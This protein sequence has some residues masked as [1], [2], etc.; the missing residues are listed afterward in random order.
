MCSFVIHVAWMKHF[1]RC[2]KTQN[3]CANG[4]VS[5][6]AMMVSSSGNLIQKRQGLYQQRQRR[7][8][9]IVGC[10]L[11]GQKRATSALDSKA[12]HFPKTSEAAPRRG[13]GGLRWRSFRFGGRM[14]SPKG[15]LEGR[16]EYALDF[17]AQ[18]KV[19]V[20]VADAVIVVGD[21]R[22]GAFVPHQVDHAVDQGT[23]V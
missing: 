22:R 6:L 17:I 19:Q 15:T 3:P 9:T 21:R 1:G 14:V 12:N 8:L 16:F 20:S 11:L 18:T 2:V 10:L 13:A 23:V 4:R 5:L 7:Q